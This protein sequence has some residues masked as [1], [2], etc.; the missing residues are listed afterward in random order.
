MCNGP[1]Q[2]AHQD[3]R[4]FRVPKLSWVGHTTINAH[5]KLQSQVK[6]THQ[7]MSLPLHPG[8][9]AMPHLCFSVLD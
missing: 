1:S 2:E 7:N 9:M 6:V 8:I 3:C 4:T 5:P